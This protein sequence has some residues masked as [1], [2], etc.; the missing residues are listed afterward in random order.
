MF[1]LIG[2]AESVE[3]QHRDALENLLK[4]TN[5]PVRIASAYVTDAQL[6]SNMS[7]RDISLL[8]YIRRKDIIA[9]STSLESLATLINAGVRCWY[10]TSGPRL[11]AKVYLFD[12]KFAVVTSANLTNKALDKNIEIGVQLSSVETQQLIIWFDML[13][14]R[15]KKLNLATVRK[16][17]E[18]TEEERIKFSSRWKEADKKPLLP[19]SPATELPD[20]FTTAKRFF[21]CNTN[22]RN[23]SEDETRMH[24]R[25]FAAAWEPF[26]HEKHMERVEQGDLIFM[27]AKSV[28]I[29]G[30]GRAKG[31]TQ[32]LEPD[33]SD[34]LM[35]S[36]PEWREREWR[37]PT[38]WLAWYDNDSIYPWS[39]RATFLDVTKDKYKHLRDGVL[40]TFVGVK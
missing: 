36:T 26:Q 32:I 34:R 2:K 20:L 6:L 4:Q 31:Q 14:E 1:T 23:S 12:D 27:F 10:L 24:D 9:G 8:T 30:I 25:G 18:E 15:A 33:D 7:D 40:S 22:R 21:V 38:D 19:A 17:I 5:G 13:L 28:G 11:H 16:W 37:V 39:Q 29:I 35:P 3:H